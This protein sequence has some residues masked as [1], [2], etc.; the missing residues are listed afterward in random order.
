[1]NNVQLKKESLQEITLEVMKIAVGTTYLS[2]HTSFAPL[3][4]SG[5][6]F[7][8]HQGESLEGISRPSKIS[9][10]K[11]NGDV[12]LLI[13][14][15]N[16]AFLFYGTYDTDLLGLEKVAEEYYRIFKKVEHLILEK[17]EKNK[18]SEEDNQKMAEAM[19]R[20]KGIF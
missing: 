1:M 13:T 9:L 17:S 8:L 3:G 6:T 4:C 2:D 15:K 10:R 20:L 5:D 14:N 16:G 12:E 18:I 11:H 19:Y 7:V